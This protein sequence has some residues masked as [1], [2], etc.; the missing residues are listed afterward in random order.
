MVGERAGPEGG[1]GGKNEEKKG[2]EERGLK[3]HSDPRKPLIL[4]PL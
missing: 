4:V 3:A 2:W 1:K